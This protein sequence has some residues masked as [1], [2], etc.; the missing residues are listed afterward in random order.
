MGVLQA[1]LGFLKV[2]FLSR[3]NL[4]V[5]DTAMVTRKNRCGVQVTAA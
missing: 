3:I 2:L 5:E 1:I 4:T